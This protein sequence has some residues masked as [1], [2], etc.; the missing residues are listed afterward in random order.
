MKNNN[1][2]EYLLI[3]NKQYTVIELEEEIN[4]LEEELKLVRD[5]VRN[6]EKDVIVKKIILREDTLNKQFLKFKNHQNNLIQKAI[7]L[8]K[9]LLHLA[10]GSYYDDIHRYKDY[11]GAK[12]ANNHKQAAYTIKWLTRF[13]PVQ[14][15]EEF[16]TEEFTNDKILDINLHFAL[17]CGFSFLDRKIIDLV[18]KE[19][20]EIE[21][22][23]QEN[24]ED[25]K[26]SFY[27]KLLYN[28]RFRSF[29]GKQLISIFEA[30]E[31]GIKN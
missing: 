5:T 17:I 16:D 6:K 23:N 3:E 31:L 4:N 18:F 13:K 29:T 15:R 1:F 10:V 8:N 14:I 20:K 21:L 25:K 30:L 9:G 24:K 2:S 11:S 28:I 19:K 22:L 27:D 7:Y 26:Q 12:W